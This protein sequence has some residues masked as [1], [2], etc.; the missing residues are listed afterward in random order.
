MFEKNKERKLVALG[1]VGL[2]FQQLSL[3]MFLIGQ[4]VDN[5]MYPIAATSLFSCILGLVLLLLCF[6]T[7]CILSHGSEHNVRVLNQYD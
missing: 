6:I 1:F 7:Y 4:I 5:P 3:A 2:F